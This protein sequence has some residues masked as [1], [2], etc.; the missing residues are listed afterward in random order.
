M[1]RQPLTVAVDAMGGDHAPGAILEGV[2]LALASSEDLR[3][4]LCGTA[5]VVEPFAAPRE[6]VEALVA[7]HVIE[8]GEHPATAVR[9]KP[10][11]SIVAGCRA[12]REGRADAFFSAGNTGAC[13]AAATLVMGRIEGVSRPAIATVMPAAKGRFILLDAG[14]NADCKPENLVEFAH[15]GA[16]YARVVMGVEHPAVALLNIGSEES[17]GSGLAVEAHVMMRD[18]VPGFVGNIEAG[19]VPFGG[20]DVVVTDGF[21]GNVVLKLMEGLAAALF[22]RIRESITAGPVDRLAAAVLRPRFAQIK[23]D[24]DPEAVGGAPLMGVNGVCI[25]GHGGSSPKAVEAAL[26]VAVRACRGDLVGAI[27]GALAGPAGED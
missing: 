2:G 10:D 17:K 20:A 23:R 14:A 19:A 22:G 5:D 12:V 3:I 27:R 8:M 9:S 18:A 7:S 4:L 15:M 11:S 21:T 25:I 24:L 26:G 1:S 16:A 6:A 13:M